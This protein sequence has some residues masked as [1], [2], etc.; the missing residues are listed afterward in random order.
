[1]YI[2][3]NG[4]VNAEICRDNNV[5]LAFIHIC[6][7]VIYDGY[8]KYLS[9]YKWFIIIIIIIYLNLFEEHKLTFMYS[10]WDLYF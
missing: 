9:I 10:I 2:T 5:S 4:K 3:K 6:N 8:L 7:I 1:M